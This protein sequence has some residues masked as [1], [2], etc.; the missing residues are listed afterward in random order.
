MP[1]FHPAQNL[2]FDVIRESN[3]LG[4]SGQKRGVLGHL[5]GTCLF[6]LAVFQSLV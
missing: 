4:L 2:L 6:S 5:A 1:S 3:R